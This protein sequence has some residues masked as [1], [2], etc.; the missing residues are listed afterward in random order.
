MAAPHRRANSKASSLLQ[1]QGARR[2]RGNARR[3]PRNAGRARWLRIA[4]AALCTLVGSGL[5]VVLGPWL[6]IRS[7]VVLGGTPSERAMA[8]RR[9]SVA[10]VNR[11]PWSI[12]STRVSRLISQSTMLR[13][14]VELSAVVTHWPSAVVVELQPVPLVGAIQG[15]FVLTQLGEVVARSPSSAT[16][17][18]LRALRVCAAPVQ[19]TNGSCAWHP[20]PGA[21]VSAPLVRVV[22]ALTRDV[23]GSGSP[24]I[25]IY[26]AQGAGIVL[27]FA[28][29]AECELGLAT[30][31]RAQVRACLGFATAGAVL[32][33]INPNSPAVLLNDRV[34]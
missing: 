19:S 3:L 10:L 16:P 32:D 25:G 20:R 14:E 15:G 26:E 18:A 17:T 30:Q 4:A 1:G 11:H 22:A 7:V 34:G 31:A 8:S 23:R 9:L 2:H 13:G 29:S 24:S 33:V 28:S 12:S 21:W 5:V 6:R 27:R